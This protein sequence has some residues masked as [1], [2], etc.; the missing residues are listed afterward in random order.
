MALS[1]LHILQ[2][3]KNCVP[4]EVG[5]RW[6][7][8]SNENESLNSPPSD[9]FADFAA[10]I[11]FWLSLTM[12]GLTAGLL[13]LWIDVPRAVEAYEF[14]E[15][16]EAQAVDSTDGMTDDRF[17]VTSVAWGDR[18]FQLL[19]FLWPVFLIEQAVHYYFMERGTSFRRQHRYW[20]AFCLLPPLR[21]CARHRSDRDR[22][23]LPRG[24]WQIADHQLQHQ[25]ERVFSLPMIG[26]A[27]LI[28]PVLGLQTY[29]QDRIV[30]YPV[31]RIM[32]HAGTGVIWFAF[33]AEFI[34][35]ISVT[36]RKLEY[37]RRHWLDLVIILLPLVSFLRSL[38]SL[39]AAKLIKIGKLQQVSRLTRVYRLRGV[40]LR[41]W[42]ALVLLE[43]VQRLLHSSPEKRIRQLEEICIEKE[44]ELKYLREQ[45]QHL[46]R[47]SEPR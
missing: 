44:R 32:L 38:R 12:L 4:A 2:P 8:L 20:W 6:N 5:R 27:L 42:R 13:V 14:A 7:L 35:M 39:R 23:W 17:A 41:G 26:I 16:L 47:Q 22:I 25:L 29:L 40:A 46:R 21:M 19:M 31:L 37:C 36:R 43:V 15:E 3:G 9:R 24:G 34:V 1:R 33:A 30:D 45:I 10:P 28:L 11:M 18:V